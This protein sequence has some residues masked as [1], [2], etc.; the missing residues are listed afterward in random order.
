MEWP[1]NSGLAIGSESSGGVRNVTFDNCNLYMAR[2][3]VYIK[4]E[5]GRGGESKI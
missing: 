5:R 3:G 1:T 2:V 4:S